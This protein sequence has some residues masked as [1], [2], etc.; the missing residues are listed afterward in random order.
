MHAQLTATNC[1]AEDVRVL[2]KVA[3][4]NLAPRDEWQA[5]ISSGGVE[6]L[7]SS[8]LHLGFHRHRLRSGQC[9]GRQAPVAKGRRSAPRH[10]PKARRLH[11][12]GRRSRHH[13]LSQ[14]SAGQKIYSTNGLERLD[15]EIKR[16][17]EVVGIFPH[18]SSPMKKKMGSSLKGATDTRVKRYQVFA[19]SYSSEGR[20][21]YEALEYSASAI[22]PKCF[23]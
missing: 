6:N 11:G 16:Q 3:F 20:R 13:D 15:G 19:R 18:A 1:R 7:K 4:S 9:G 12:R 21:M 17:T 8:I 14:E 23:T 2:R 5:V 10:A 22:V